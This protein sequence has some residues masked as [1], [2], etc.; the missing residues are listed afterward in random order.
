M[1]RRQH[2]E[3]EK[4]AAVCSFPPVDLDVGNGAQRVDVLQRP[5]HV[6]NLEGFA[7]PNC[8]G[9]GRRLIENIGRVHQD[10]G[11]GDSLEG[12]GAGGGDVCGF[13]PGVITTS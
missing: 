9:L 5:A 2:G 6:G 8:E 11:D 12:I 13:R 1:R 3:L 4:H 7:Y 10:G